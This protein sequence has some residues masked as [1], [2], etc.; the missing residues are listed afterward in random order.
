MRARPKSAKPTESVPEAPDLAIVVHEMLHHIDAIRIHLE[1]LA[2]MLAP[3]KKR[4][5]KAKVPRPRATG[6]NGS[7]RPRPR[8]LQ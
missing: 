1:D 6:T 5:P 3:A 7:A 8:A 4:A 2:A